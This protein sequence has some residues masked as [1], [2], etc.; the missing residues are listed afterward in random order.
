MKTNEEQLENEKHDH[1]CSFMEVIVLGGSKTCQR[2]WD[3]TGVGKTTVISVT[4][5]IESPAN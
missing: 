5:Y 1:T 3:R 4:S 2:E